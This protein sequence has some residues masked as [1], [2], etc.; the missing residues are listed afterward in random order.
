MTSTSVHIFTESGEGIG[1]GHLV[2]MNVVAEEVQKRGLTCHKLTDHR[3]RSSIPLLEGWETGEWR[4]APSGSEED[5]GAAIVDSY[6]AGVGVYEAL[7]GRF[8]P[9]LAIDDY[10]RIDYP[11]DLVVNP[12]PSFVESHRTGWTG[13]AQFVLLRNEVRAGGPRSDQPAVTIKKTAITL[14]GSDPH[15]LL[16]EVLSEASTWSGEISVIA[17]TEPRKIEIERRFPGFAGKVYGTL[18]ADGMRERFGES[19]LVL[20]ACGQ[21]L[22]ELA[23]LRIPTIGFCVGEDQTLN[24][25]FYLDRGFL[26]ASIDWRDPKWK[27]RLVEERVRMADRNYRTD[28]AGAVDG[29]IDGRGAERL[30]DLL[31]GCFGM[32]N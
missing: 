5:G 29:L 7:A 20:S 1:Y 18:S 17:G 3:G 15:G 19:D 16:P 30:V 9:V 2:R 31:V 14:G 13:G 10:G 32:A 11:V 26:G 25:K 4:A 12:N 8:S 24:Q 21:T 28:R 6:L 22:H 27:E 23:Y